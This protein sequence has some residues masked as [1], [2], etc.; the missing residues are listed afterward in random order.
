MAVGRAQFL[1]TAALSRWW[2]ERF[3][4]GP[5]EWLWR[6]FTLWGWQPWRIPVS[7]SPVPA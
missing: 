1:A 6:S 5:L 2:L 4:F 7:R 3:R